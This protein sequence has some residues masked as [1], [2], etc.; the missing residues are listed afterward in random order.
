MGF[1]ELLGRALVCS[2]RSR[3]RRAR[4]CVCVAS[5]FS[6]RMQITAMPWCVGLERQSVNLLSVLPQ[7]T[8]VAQNGK[9][10]RI[11]FP[12]FDSRREAQ[13]GV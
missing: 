9:G 12:R 3:Y 8:G 13:S 2:L 7:E 1:V 11:D 10:G 5:L 4:V 6:S